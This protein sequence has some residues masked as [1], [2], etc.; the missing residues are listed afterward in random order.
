MDKKEELVR[1]YFTEA[2]GKKIYSCYKSDSPLFGESYFI[3]DAYVIYDYCKEDI[4][5]LSLERLQ[6]IYDVLGPL[7]LS[8]KLIGIDPDNKIK[9]TKLVHGDLSYEDKPS[10]N[11]I[12]N[13][14][15]AL[16]KLHKNSSE[17]DVAPDLVSEFYELK[18]F[19]DKKIGKILENRIV[20]EFKEIK[21]K[22]PLGLC[23]NY[24]SKDNVIY[25]YDSVLFVD[26]ELG[27][28]N[29]L[30][31]DLASY[32]FLNNIDDELRYLFLTTYFGA[33]YNSLKGK[34]VEIFLNFVKA[35]YYYM[36]QYLYKVTNNEKYLNLV[37]AM[38]FE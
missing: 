38:K 15:K 10:E 33:S 19:A 1:Q 31:F 22:T 2:L 34:R 21:D 30:Y 23:H 11:Q 37:E 3:N 14:A 4:S 25:R 17:Y 35:Y 5:L 16:K 36:Y 7:N 9:V 27:N 6:S 24:L 29:Y 12:R 32:I 26:Y 18:E 20:R 8:E 13:V 28:I